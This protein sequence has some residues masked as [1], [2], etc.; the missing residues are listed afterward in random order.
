MN[1]NNLSIK[2]KALI[3]LSP[4]NVGLVCE[5]QR[6]SDA[7]AKAYETFEIMGEPQVRAGL[8]RPCV[9]LNKSEI[10]EERRV[11]EVCFPS[12]KGRWMPDKH[13]GHGGY[14]DYMDDDRWHGWITRA[15]L[16]PN[17]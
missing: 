17:V 5:E 15:I 11:F 1:I 3:G 13:N 8:V 14:Q 6:I 7:K 4:L 9:V 12:A 16:S 10:E 2:F